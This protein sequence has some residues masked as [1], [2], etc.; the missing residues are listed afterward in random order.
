MEEQQIAYKGTPA[1]IS[2]DFSA[3]TLHTGRVV[4]SDKIDLNIKNV[5]RDKEGHYLMIKRSIEGEDVT[6]VN[7]GIPALAQ[8]TE[9]QDQK[10]SHVNSILKLTPLLLKLFQNITEKEHSQALIPKPEKETTKKEKITWH[11]Q[12]GLAGSGPHISAKMQVQSL[13][14][15][16]RLRSSYCHKLRHSLQMQLRSSAA[17]A[18]V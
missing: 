13:A 7:I 15:L 9:V 8:Q 16:R 2:A 1:R 18:V 11:S 12:C 5:T 10:V 4:I 3:E 6:M 17:M 14:S